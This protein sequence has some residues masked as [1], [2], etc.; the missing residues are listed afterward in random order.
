MLTP[1]KNA[2]RRIDFDPGTTDFATDSTHVLY[3]GVTVRQANDT[4]LRRGA[5]NSA[6][7]DINLDSHK[8]IN[9]ADP[10]NDKDSNAGPNKV[11]KS[12]DIM[13]EIYIRVSIQIQLVCSGVPT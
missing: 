3:R 10:T 9:V 13:T 12:G 6:A 1:C 5:G 11:S 8:L 7:N 2:R 4:F